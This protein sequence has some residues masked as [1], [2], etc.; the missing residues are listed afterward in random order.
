MLYAQAFHY[1][2]TSKS[3]STPTLISGFQYQFS[4]Y[5]F[6]RTISAQTKKSNGFV[7]KIK[8]NDKTTMVVFPALI[9]S[10]IRRNTCDE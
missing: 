4:F 6:L 10:P 9:T 2:W 1:R 7:A 3:D 5:E 8:G